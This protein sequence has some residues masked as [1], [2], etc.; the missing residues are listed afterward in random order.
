MTEIALAAAIEGAM[1]SAGSDYWAIP[2]EL[3]SGWRTPGGHATP[4]PKLIEPGDLVHVEFAG[5]SA[6]YHA[7][8]LQT[9]AVG[10]P[11]SR[12]R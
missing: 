10:D 4:G 3:A 11:G 7:T 6:R 1:R 5:V 12:E 8:A 9:L 2:T